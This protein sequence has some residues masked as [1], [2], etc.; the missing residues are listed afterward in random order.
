[1]IAEEEFHESLA[2][3]W[4]RRLVG[5]SSEEARRLLVSATRTMLPPMLAWLGAADEPAAALVSAGITAPAAELVANYR[6]RVRALVAGVGV[7]VDAVTPAAGWD[8]ARGRGPGRP[9]AD[10]CERARG[11]R[12]RMLLVE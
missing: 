8:P 3:A 9:D 12:N 6:N 11:D 7:D 5:S 2:V 1:M 10:A 4:Y